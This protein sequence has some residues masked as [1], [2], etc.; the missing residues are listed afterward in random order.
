MSG[1][2]G[3]LIFNRLT[4][5]RDHVDW[6]IKVLTQYADF[7]GRARRMEY[8]MFTLISTIVGAVLGVLSGV[9]SLRGST[10][11]GL[12]AAIYLLATIIPSIAV[13]VR[14]LHDTGRSGWWMFISL[15]PFVGF[16]IVLYFQL[17]PG[18]PHANEYGPD[19]KAA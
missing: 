5:E 7:G 10:G 16:L 3:S 11:M 18:E 14:R 12:L 19:P 17:Q 2:G 6:Y 4:Q 13:A 8:W 15:I 1:L 9:L